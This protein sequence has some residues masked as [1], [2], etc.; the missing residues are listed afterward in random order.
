MYSKS[1]QSG[2][3]L[4]ELLVVIAIIGILTAIGIPMYSGYQASAKVS[5]TKQN[6]DSLKTYIA[7]E[8]TKCGAGLVANLPTVGGT[9]VACDGTQTAA[10]YQAYFVTYAN[11]IFKN[12]Y[13]PSAPTVAFAT[14]PVVSASTAG[15]LYIDTGAC[16]GGLAISSEFVDDT[17]GS[18]PYPNTVAS[19][20]ATAAPSCISIQ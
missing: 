10:S 15:Q 17:L 11:S 14:P 9:T 16:S 12:P 1:K 18:V 2:F 8:V 5:A 6:L 7:G 20:K 19:G 3:T 13:K 4:I